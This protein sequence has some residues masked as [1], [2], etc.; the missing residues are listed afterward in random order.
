MCLWIEIGFREGWV[1][2]CETVCIYV[3]V[4]FKALSDVT[5]LN[6]PLPPTLSLFFLVL[7]HTNNKNNKNNNQ[8]VEAAVEVLPRWPLG[9]VDLRGMSKANTKHCKMLH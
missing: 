3:A 9:P 4:T 7:S 6:C 2:E 5:P 8:Q 1:K